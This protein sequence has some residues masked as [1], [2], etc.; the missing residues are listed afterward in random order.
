MVNISM[1]KKVS[2]IVPTY[3]RAGLLEHTIVSI[4]NQTYQNIELIIVSDGST[5]QT[6]EMVAKY[7]NSDDRIRFFEIE[8]SGR[9][10]VPRNEGISRATG[11]Y[12]ALCDD[13]DIW[14]NEKLE[15]QIEYFQQADVIGVASRATL[16]FEE[17]ISGRPKLHN[18]DAPS[19]KDYSF[20]QIILGNTVIN[21]SFIARRSTFIEMGG[22]DEQPCFKFIEDWELWLRMSCTGII[23]ILSR[24]LVEYR[25]YS[26]RRRDFSTV[27]MNKILLLNKMQRMSHLKNRGLHR[28]ALA[29]VYADIGRALLEE[30][31]KDALTFFQKSLHLASDMAVKRKLRTRIL[32]L[33]CLMPCS[34]KSKIIKFLRR[35]DLLK[36]RAAFK[37]VF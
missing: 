19:F 11:D 29:N 1:S 15:T 4:L 18:S 31:D 32:M 26:D 36:I 21:S 24:P 35:K 37:G 16:L 6:K 22:F 27:E 17:E 10:A 9:P 2:V 20:E 8:N 30:N 12:I 14:I 28:N 3:N 13:D 7:Q 34:L 5:D 23:R 33:I 25:I